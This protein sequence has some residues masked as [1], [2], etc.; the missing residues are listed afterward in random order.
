MVT[1]IFEDELLTSWLV[2]LARANSAR[3]H[4]FTVDLF[5]RKNPERPHFPTITHWHRDLDRT[6]KSDD[7]EE[8]ARRT[9]LPIERVRQTTLEPLERRLTERTYLGTGVARWLLPIGVRELMRLDCGLQYCP[10]CLR[11]DASPYFR[12]IWRLAFVTICPVHWT[13]LL[14]R[15]P[16]CRNPIHFARR[17]FGGDAHRL[18]R[19]PISD[20]YECGFDLRQAD[21][22]WGSEVKR[23]V[24]NREGGHRRTGRGPQHRSRSSVSATRLYYFQTWLLEGLNRG[25]FDL[26]DLRATRLSGRVDHRTWVTRGHSK[27][28]SPIQT[29]RVLSGEFFDGLRQAVKLLASDCGPN[30]SLPWTAQTFAF[31]PRNREV[32]K[33][34]QLVRSKVGVRKLVSSEYRVSDAFERM[35]VEERRIV[36][37]MLAYTMLGWPNRF[38]ALCVQSGMTESKVTMD[39]SRKVRLPTWFTESVNQQL[40]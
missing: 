23:P 27:R 37:M 4:V 19:A 28:A 14:D 35:P 15:C 1:P 26:A 18:R 32:V 33:L 21:A 25:L 6:F 29:E 34:C 11:E 13:P 5:G 3:L 12:R 8:L 38:V 31:K 22:D 17:E 16:D 24:R 36:M 2:R 30:K 20:C 9:E 7:L 40:G 39:S 10:H